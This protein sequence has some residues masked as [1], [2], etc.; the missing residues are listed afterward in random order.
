M[1]RIFTPEK[2]EIKVEIPNS[3]SISHRIAILAAIKPGITEIK[4]FL[5]SEDTEITLQALTDMGAEFSRNGNTVTCSGQIGSVRSAKIF[6]GNSG[7]SARFLLP[8]AALCDQ[9]V[10]FSGTER[11]HQ[12]PVHELLTAM[13]QLGIKH[14]SNGN[15]LPVT[16]FPSIASGSKLKFDTLSSSQVVTA[17]LLMAVRMSAGL[18]IEFGRSVPSLP[19]IGLTFRLMHHLNLDIQKIENGYFVRPGVPATDWQYK[20]EKDM[21]S[22]SYWVV[23][24]LISGQKV[25][26]QNVVPPSIQGDERIFAIAE[27]IGAEVELYPD[28][29]E[30][31]GRIKNSFDIDCN[32]IPDLVPSLA[33][34]A[35]FA[36]EKCILRNI[37]HLEYKE[38]NRI[39]VVCKNINNLGGSCEYNQG[40]IQISPQPK[41]YKGCT[42]KCFDDHRIAMA[43]AVAGIRI[44]NVVID[45]PP[46]VSKSYPEFWDHFRWW[47]ETE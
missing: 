17:M 8:L 44:E 12:R 47:K 21:S 31:S 10:T 15:K 2:K 25:V 45:N 29:V 9:P 36:P 19:Y 13:E 43:F 16:V 37:E 41:K 6:F 20:V 38:S 40:S 5:Y 35:M 28:R 34:L 1:Y 27:S 24:A 23:L 4:N 33:V 11:L 26:L 3:K 42:I 18:E 7:S 14:K 22:A 39:E 46:V 30:I 32:G